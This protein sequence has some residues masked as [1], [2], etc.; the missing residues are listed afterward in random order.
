MRTRTPIKHTQLLDK[1]LDKI[2][3]DVLSNA[4]SMTEARNQLAVLA[5]K[6]DVYTDYLDGYVWGQLVGLAQLN[7]TTNRA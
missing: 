4:I 7:T 1:A 2:V 5:T 6:Y 3:A